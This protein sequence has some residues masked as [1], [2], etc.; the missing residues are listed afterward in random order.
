MSNNLELD[1]AKLKEDMAKVKSDLAKLIGEVN[2]IVKRF[3]MQP[4]PIMRDS[5]KPGRSDDYFFHGEGHFVD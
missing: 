2:K 1:V 5:L 3:E 4:P